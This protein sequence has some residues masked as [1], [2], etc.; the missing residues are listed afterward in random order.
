MATTAP[1]SS[2]HKR[3]AVYSADRS[4]SYLFLAPLTARLWRRIGYGSL[5]ILVGP[6]HAWRHNPTQSLA[7]SE[8][9]RMGARLRYVTEIP[10]YASSTIA[11]LSRLFAAATDLP[12]E[13]FLLTA[14]A[15][16]WPLSAEHFS[17]LAT[18]KSF[19]ILY[20]NAYPQTGPFPRFPICYLGASAARWREI[21]R[22]DKPLPNALAEQL[23]FGLG[24]NPPSWRAWNYD[25]WLFGEM[26]E[27]WPAYPGSC[28]F[29]S[30][31]SPASQP[32]PDRL[33]RTHWRDVE[34][35]NGLIDAHVLHPAYSREN[36]PRLR[37]LLALALTPDEVA[38]VD[39]YHAA[40]IR[41]LT[42]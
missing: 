4:P 23:D 26:L 39:A 9:A 33:D 41:V 1:S 12:P 15:D 36:W 5:I 30:R 32:P 34:T 19:Q 25:E 13:T 17:Q 22:I 7:A 37:R 28:E 2:S 29:H 38:E 42:L 14:D 8:L 6:E 3:L 18:E 31:A 35:L 24:P 40:F 20:A 11:Q 16:M 27:C 10:G 21:M